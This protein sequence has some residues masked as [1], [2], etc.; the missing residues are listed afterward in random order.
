[1][2]NL[3]IV[4]L[5]TFIIVGCNSP[6][7]KA[8]LII[9]NAVIWTADELVPVAEAIAISGDLILAVGS[10][11]EILTYHG[12][13]TEVIDAGGNFITPGFI[14]SHVHFL[15]GG[16]NLLSV[17]LR[18][19]GTKVEFIKRIKEYAQTVEPGTWI[20]GG[21]WDHTNWGGELPSREWVDSVTTG[22][23]LVINRLDGH[24]ILANS[25][26]LEA[27]GVTKSVQDVDGGTIV[28]NA[29]GEL[30]G[31]FKDNAMGMTYS[32]VPE[33]SDLQKN[34]A[35]SAAMNYVVSNGV[36]SV[37]NMGGRSGEHQVLKQA[38]ENNN[39][40]VRIYDIFPL[41]A[42]QSLLSEI[43]NNGRGDNWLKIGG[44]KGFMDGSLGSHTAAFFEPFSDTPDDSG[45]LVNS[46]EE[47]YEWISSADSA[48]LQVMV[49]AIGDKAI[50]ALLNIY[51]RVALE[52]ENLNRRFRI[53][54]AQHISPPDIPRFNKQNVIPGM[55][56]YHAI[57]DGRWAKNVIGEERIKTTY[58]FKSLLENNARLAFGSDWF[59]APPTPLEGIYAAV[60]RRTLDEANPD[61]WVPE[62]KITVE[63]ALIAYTINAAYAGFDEDI[64]GS[65]SVGKLADLVMI[66]A[67]LLGIPAEEIRNASVVLTLVGGQIVYD[68]R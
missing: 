24:M 27:A 47:M 36:T 57:D 33:P 59:V 4:S 7:Q 65:L 62:E 30:T 29:Q 21:D 54:H 46:E 23:P 17:Q 50:N 52:N 56:P 12:N 20:M 3:T 6:S 11:E 63:E 10:T 37:H 60:T 68:N 13:Q 9:T 44:L 1:M 58:A 64:K 25:A 67:N 18:D 49:H 42:W 15:D 41:P 2:R 61:G 28:R 53:E 34:A 14:D 43:E 5:V 39:L 22:H 38:R 8:D 51:E 19:A 31:I 35:L 26:A 32:A 45:F 16:F 40:T 48:G 66:N 55:Q